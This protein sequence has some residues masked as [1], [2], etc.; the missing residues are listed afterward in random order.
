MGDLKTGIILDL[1]GN[2]DRQAKRFESSLGRLGSRGSRAMR[3]LD[4]TLGAVGNGL[5]RIG[6]RYTALITGAAGVGTARFLIGLEERFTMLGIQADVN[7]EK[8]DQLKKRIFDVARMPNIRID[9]GELTSAVEDIVEKTGDLKFAQDNLENFAVAISATGGKTGSAIGQISAEF[10]KMGIVSKKDVAEALDI[11]TVQGKAGAFTLQNLATLGSRTVTAY[12]AMGR[13]GVPAIRE[14]GA[15][16]QMIRQGTGSS[17]MA[18]T[19]FEALLRTLGDAKKVKLLQDGGIKVFDEEAAKDGR[20]VLRSLPSLMEEIIRTTGG[21]KTVLSKVFDAEAIRAFNAAAG[22]FTR[23]GGVESLDRFM[24]VHA[25]GTVLLKDSQ[26]AANDSGRA[27]RNLYTAWQQFA[28]RNLSGPLEKAADAL[29][30]L[31]SET[32]DL[33]LKIAGIGGGVVGAAVVGRSVYNVGRGVMGMFG[34]GAGSKLPGAAGAAG[35]GDAIPVY[36]VNGP[37]SIW[38]GGGKNSGPAGLVPDGMGVMGGAGVAMLPV[39][40]TAAAA[41]GSEAAGKALARQEAKYTSTEGLRKLAARNMVMGGGGADNY[42][43]QLIAAELAKRG[44]ANGTI[45][46]EVA[47]AP[48]WATKATQITAKNVDLDVDSGR[49][50]RGN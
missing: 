38:P 43:S 29:N 24:E 2:L 15:A 21:K 16:L 7:G 40:V 9:P 18:A 8:I 1:Q 6:N 4:R 50:M 11:L 35:F 14:M 44:E 36:V 10:Q 19:A 33:W 49:I 12:T 46:I 13:T 37:A 47:P 20:E 3:G 22:E 26:R 31:D 5:D 28:D 23:T 25:D 48:G 41:A 32:V 34:R 17:E 30:S 27:L 39:A 45:K 42:Q